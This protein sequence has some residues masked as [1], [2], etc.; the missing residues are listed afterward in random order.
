MERVP[1]AR[2]I[3]FSSPEAEFLDEIQ[4]NVLR[5]FL[6]AIYSHLYSFA[7]RFL[8]LQT[9]ATSYS[10]YSSVTLHFKGEKR[11]T[12]YKQYPLPYGRNPYNLKSENSQ[13]YAQKPQR[14]CTVMNSASREIKSCLSYHNDTGDTSGEK[15]WTIR[16]LA[17]N[18]LLLYM[19]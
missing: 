6:L 5:I 1:L 13:D 8:F 17:Q 2:D 3:C 14:N 18:L 9:Q 15:Y 12:W 10:F 4:T 16:K 7:L 11:K 19:R